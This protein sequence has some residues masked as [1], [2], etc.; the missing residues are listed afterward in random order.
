M[1]SVDSI[2]VVK[3][4]HDT[5]YIKSVD[6]FDVINKVDAFYRSAW[7]NIVEISAAILAFVSIAMPF[8]LKVDFRSNRSKLQEDIDKKTK[9]STQQLKNEIKETIESEIKRLETDVIK[10]TNEAMAAVYFLQANAE[11]KEGKIQASF[12]SYTI[13]CIYFSYSESFQNLYRALNSLIDI[14][15]QMNKEQFMQMEQDKKFYMDNFID[16]IRTNDTKGSMTDVLSKI[17][18]NYN[19]VFADRKP[20]HNGTY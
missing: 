15:P 4:I 16:T 5:I 2:Q 11:L 20:R 19:D 9:E 3:V 14:V 12:I 7:Y 1:I 17:I 8:I 13:C 6:N 10:A 18:D